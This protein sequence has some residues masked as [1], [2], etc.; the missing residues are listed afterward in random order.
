MFTKDLPAH[1]EIEITIIGTGGGYGESIVIHAGSNDWVVIDSCIN[2][3]SKKSLPLEYLQDIGV[4]VSKDVKYIIC[5]HWHDDHVRGISELYRECESAE[6]CFALANDLRKYLQFLSLDYLKLE[7]NISACS[8]T[9]FNAC[10]ELLSSREQDIF[11]MSRDILIHNTLIGEK[12]VQLYALS[13][14]NY[15]TSLFE[16]EISRLITDYGEKSTKVLSE[17]PNQRSVA[18][19]FKFGTTS[20]ILGSDLEV[21]DNNRS[22]WLNVLDGINCMNGEPKSS[23]FKIPHHGSENGY[24]S[25]IWE[26]LL[27]ENPV[28]TMTTWFRGDGLPQTEMV[29]KYKLHTSNL[30]ITNDLVKLKEKTRTSK[31]KK[32]LKE[33]GLDIKEVKFS[34]GLIRGRFNT[35]IGPSKWE[36]ETSGTAF[37]L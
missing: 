14:S 30:Y 24:A 12:R 20:A 15:T 25:R 1:G 16:K 29:E 32:T 8:T 26:E 9:E 36:I 34:E 5:T 35:Q 23:Y 28:G 11:R 4:N 18:L 2:P 22:G 6:F 17:T 33:L 10:L 19:Y 37:R 3:V 27:V 31:I 7:S 13:P 21:E